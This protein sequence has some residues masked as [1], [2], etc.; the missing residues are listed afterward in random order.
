MATYLGTNCSINIKYDPNAS[1]GSR[2]YIFYGP[3]D[4]AETS[5]TQTD[6]ISFHTDRD[7]L[8]SFG[9]NITLGGISVKDGDVVKFDPA[10]VSGTI[11][12]FFDEQ[13]SQKLGE[14][15]DDDIV[16]FESASDGVVYLL[17]GS[18]ASLNGANS[19]DDDE[20]VHGNSANNTAVWNFRARRISRL[21]QP[22]IWMPSTPS[23]NQQHR[24]CSRELG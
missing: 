15:Y 17:T 2:A 24:R 8:L 22:L 18:S 4:A 20:I 14:S 21:Q 6:A 19:F 16:G 11:G 3:N 10:D 23:L 1:P 5:D 7:L 12:I 9:S 13:N